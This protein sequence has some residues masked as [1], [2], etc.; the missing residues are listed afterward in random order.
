MARGGRGWQGRQLFLGGRG[1][2]GRA[3]R[4]MCSDVRTPGSVPVPLACSA[5]FVPAK[6]RLP[7]GGG[8]VHLTALTSAQ[9][10]EWL[11]PP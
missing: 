9:A 8:F 6:T 4:R 11:P 3:A 10:E 1:G 2:A 7:P 5:P